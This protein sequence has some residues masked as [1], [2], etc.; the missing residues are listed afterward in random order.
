MVPAQHRQVFAVVAEW[1]MACHS[2]GWIR[3][4]QNLSI[5]LYLPDADIAKISRR[6]RVALK[7][8]VKHAG[9]HIPAA[10]QLEIG[11]R[12]TGNGLVAQFGSKSDGGCFGQ[13]LQT[14]ETAARL[15]AETH[16]AG[17]RQIRMPKLVSRK[18]LLSVRLLR[19]FAS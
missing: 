12:Q 1:G 3:Q 10:L 2:A 5:V 4:Q 17:L 11:Q 7:C 14:V 19:A 18:M 6:H 8:A 15:A 13:R 16:R 9:L